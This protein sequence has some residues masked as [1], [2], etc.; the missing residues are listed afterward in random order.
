MHINRSE[1]FCN[2][3]TPIGTIFCNNLT[4]IGAIFCNILTAKPIS[5]ARSVKAE[6]SRGM[7]QS[8]MHL[9]LYVCWSG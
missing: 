9:E 2:N 3:L 6:T 4:P 5:E 1:L 7:V 8:A